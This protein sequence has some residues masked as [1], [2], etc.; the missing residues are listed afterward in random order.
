MEGNSP[1]P[2][3]GSAERNFEKQLSAMFSF[4]ASRAGIRIGNFIAEGQIDSEFVATKKP[5]FNGKRRLDSSMTMESRQASSSEKLRRT[6]G[7]RPPTSA[8]HATR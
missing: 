2:E 6:Q 8:H 5:Y 4:F 3:A 1:I 7:N